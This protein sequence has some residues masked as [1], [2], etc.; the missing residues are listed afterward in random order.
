M[1]VLAQAPA[2]GIKPL[3][4]FIANL[5]QGW[6]IPLMVMLAVL[7]VI[8][9]AVMYIQV[10][11]NSTVKKEKREQIFWGIIGL[12]VI[13]SVWSLVSVVQNTFQVFSGGTLQSNL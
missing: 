7:Y 13:L 3:I 9:A 8:W 2:S 1:L 11:D 6:L 5:F 10:D 12:F 4:L